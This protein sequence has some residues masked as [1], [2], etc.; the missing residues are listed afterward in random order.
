MENERGI[1]NRYR[2]ENSLNYAVNNA[3]SIINKSYLER[4]EDMEIVKPSLEDKDIDIAQCGKFYKLDKLVLNK[5]E[6]FIDKLITIV[7]V[8]SAVDGTIATIINSDGNNVNYYIGIISK[9]YRSDNVKNKNIRAGM[10]EAFSGA[11]AGNFAGSELNGMSEDEVERMRADIFSDVKAVSAVSGIVSLRDKNKKNAESYVQGIENFINSVKNKKYTVI[12]FAD[13]V[14][15]GEIQN[16]KIGYEMIYTQ[17]SYFLKTVATMSENESQSE[18]SARTEGIS[19]GITKGITEGITE[20]ISKTTSKS[21]FKSSNVGVNVGFSF[22]PFGIGPSIGGSYGRS[23]GSTESYS[24]GMSY[25]KARSVNTG[26]TSSTMSSTTSS[27]G[28]SKGTGKSIQFSNENRVVKDLMDKI[29]I[30]VKRLDLCESFGAFECATYVLAENYE[31]SL[32]VSSNYNGLMRGE[33]SFVESSKI[34]TWSKSR[35]GNNDKVETLISYLKSFVHPNFYMDD[36]KKIKVTPAS[37]VNGKEVAIQMG[38]PK[39]SINGLTV[40]EMTPFGRNVTVNNE[41]CIDIGQLY[42]M[43]KSDNVPLRLD[44]QSLA[45]HTFITGSTGSGKSNTIYNMLSELGNKNIKFLVVEPAKGEYKNVFGRRDDVTV[46][47]TNP[48][49]SR[50]LKINPF[51]FPEGIHVFEHIDR[52]IE[53]FNVCWP[54]YAAMPAVLKKAVLQA[55]ENCGWDLISSENKNGYNIYPNFIDLLNELVSVIKNSAYSEEVKSNYT[56]SLVTRVETLTNGL[57]SLVFA[58]DE[59]GDDILFDTNVII[60]L[61]RVGSM[62]TKSLIMGVLVMRLGEYRMSEN[63]GM[64]LPL[65]HVTVLE[66]AHN[67][68]KRTSTEQDPE[69]PSLSGK[70]VELISNAIAEMRTYGEGFIIA[71]Q[72]PSAVDTSAIKNTNTKIVMRLP[73]EIDRRAAGK[74]AALTDEQIS[75]IARLQKGVAAIYQN[76]WV[77]PVLC[78][79]NKFEGDETIYFYS[80]NANEGQNDKKVISEALK[81]LLKNNTVEKTE[82]DI[83]FLKENIDK[84]NISTRAKLDIESAIREYERNKSLGFWNVNKFNVQAKIVTNL[85]TEKTNIEKIIFS[86]NDFKEANDMFLNIIDRKTEDLSD[87]LKISI[88]QCFMKEFSIDNPDRIEIYSAWRKLATEGRLM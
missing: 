31:D 12:M 78:K 54:M 39:K 3:A 66:E 26:T 88:I 51:K 43:G 61:S 68:L 82:P 8:A 23:K 34:N 73:D 35:F 59:T 70:S 24:E 38:F 72:S 53:I 50:L 57:N 60:D 62:E 32:M 33:E 74:A 10:A 42:Y 80:N 1:I 84:A 9:K 21:T 85:V 5:E 14:G 22:A 15:E 64:N 36:E 6:N 45:S 18:S 79:I 56:G 20:G 25:S 29:D 41:N 55:Y 13:P 77:E 37:V 7:N 63:K 69:N 17:L 40:I 87:G 52:L 49:Y 71:D 83:M 67:I 27:T 48:K 46:L 81:L 30:I 76:D 16:V 44:V 11:V 86:A 19:Q 28:T 2:N 75:E 4:L 47:G 65:R 58:S